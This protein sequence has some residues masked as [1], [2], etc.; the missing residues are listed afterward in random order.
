[1]RILSQRC[2]SETSNMFPEIL[3]VLFFH[4]NVELES[5]PSFYEKVVCKKIPLYIV[6]FSEGG[7]GGFCR[8]MFRHGW[9]FDV[10]DVLVQLMF[11]VSQ[12][13]SLAAPSLYI[14]KL[15]YNAYYKIR[16]HTCIPVD[17]ESQFW[18]NSLNWKFYIFFNMIIL[19]LTIVSLLNLNINPFQNISG[20]QD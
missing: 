8:S 15:E 1:M 14:W 19:L 16:L 18:W 9:C 10:V 5:S 7:E 3:L 17:C 11:E 12:G 2:L 13:M 20:L 4:Q 6:F